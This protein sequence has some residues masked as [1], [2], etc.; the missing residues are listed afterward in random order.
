MPQVML[1]EELV[2][3]VPKHVSGITILPVIH[4][5]LP[6]ERAWVKAQANVSGPGFLETGR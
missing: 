6:E 5:A 2:P 3:T 4:A 1:K